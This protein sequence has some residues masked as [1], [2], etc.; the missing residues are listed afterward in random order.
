MSNDV[1][2]PRIDSELHGRIRLCYFE[3]NPNSYSSI[4]EELVRLSFTEG[5]DK[6][7]WY[8]RVE[9]LADNEG[10]S[11]NETL[12]NLVMSTLN[13]DGSFKAGA[14]QIYKRDNS[15]GE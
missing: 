1:F 4:Y 15:I 3:E 13:E 8:K 9:N 7:L 14:A 11:V 6:D 2:R 5:G 12:N 10:I